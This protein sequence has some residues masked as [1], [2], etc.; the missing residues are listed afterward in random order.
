MFTSSTSFSEKQFF[1]PKMVSLLWYLTEDLNLL[2]LF[3]CSI[4][5]T[6]K[7]ALIKVSE[8]VEENETLSQTRLHVTNTKMKII[9][10]Y[11]IENR[12]RLISLTNQLKI[13]H[14]AASKVLSGCLSSTPIQLLLIDPTSPVENYFETPSTFMLWTCSV[15]PLTIT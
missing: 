8:N 5:L 9:V 11:V 3:D 1:L 7:C 6:A 13:L 14:R 10:E 12:R 15:P 4:G 2:G